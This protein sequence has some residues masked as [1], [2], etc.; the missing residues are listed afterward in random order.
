[1]SV[2]NQ[3]LRYEPQAAG[4]PIS[5]TPVDYFGNLN[6]YLN[7]SGFLS[8]GTVTGYQKHRPAPRIYNI[9]LGVQ[10]G[11][12]FD[13][14]VDVKY[15][16]TLARN[17]GTTRA[18]NTVPYGTRFT[19]L[20]MTQTGSPALNENYVHPYPDVTFGTTDAIDFYGGGDGE[21]S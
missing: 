17:L 3:L 12:G 4:A 18:I 15:V 10:Q 7:L 5:Y 8:P 6:T 1:V 13:T 21:E 14:V 19:N 20:D 11:I 9:S 2:Q 16:S